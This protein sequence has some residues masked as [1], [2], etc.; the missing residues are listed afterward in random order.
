[1]SLKIHY[2]SDDNETNIFAHQKRGK[3]EL[4]SLLFFIDKTW[5]NYSFRATQ[6]V[7]DS[8]IHVSIASLAVTQPVERMQHYVW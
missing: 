7:T 5:Q 2:R 1:M 8:K 4:C 3:G 6:V